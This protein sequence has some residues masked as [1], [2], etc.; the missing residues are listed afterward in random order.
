MKFNEHKIQAGD[1]RVA[2][3]DEGKQE[4]VP[5][6]FIHGFPFNKL[7]WKNQLEVFKEHTR[8][9]AYDVRGFGNTEPGT[10]KYSIDQFGRDL[11]HFMDALRIEKAVVCGLSMGGYVALNAIEQQPE[12]IA[13]VILADT[14]CLADSEEAKKKRVD[15]IAVIQ[16]D[17][18]FEYTQDSVKKLFCE[19]SFTNKKEEIV[20]IEHTIMQ[21]KIETICHVLKALA[22]RREICPFL[23]MITIP[24]LIMVGHHDQITTLEV[25]Q[26]MH[27][28]IAG[29]ILHVIDH[30]GHVS[31]LENPGSFNLALLRFLKP[32]V[33]EVVPNLT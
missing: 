12:R 14:Q 29:S 15:T 25:A 20:F 32:A 27:E 26:K 7:M 21:T 22:D 30:A 4:G 2:Y 8:V 16:K 24:V 19:S 9:L 3:I 11:F 28:R 31:N 10:I 17:G 33:K 6:I 18:L 13:G 23:E 1:I 5:L